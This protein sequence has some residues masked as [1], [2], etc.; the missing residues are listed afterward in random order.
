[1]QS[2]LNPASASH[3]F[4]P[5][6]CQQ[7]QALHT[8]R[9]TFIYLH[10]VLHSPSV[11]GEAVKELIPSRKRRMFITS[12]R[13]LIPNISCCDNQ[14]RPP[15]PPHHSSSVSNSCPGHP[16]LDLL[17]SLRDW[18]LWGLRLHNLF[19]DCFRYNSNPGGDDP[20]SFPA[21]VNVRWV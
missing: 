17:I 12:R 19:R 11:T 20:H 16:P 15:P 18:R 3:I 21:P 7:P 9:S 10:Q 6:S 13:T 5:Y 4:I 2:V 1:M 8:K 14:H